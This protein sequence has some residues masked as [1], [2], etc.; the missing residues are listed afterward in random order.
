MVYDISSPF[1]PTAEQL[2]YTGKILEN[3]IAAL[4]AQQSPSPEISYAAVVAEQLRSYT[5]PII[6]F[7]IS[8]FEHECCHRLFGDLNFAKAAANKALNNLDKILLINSHYQLMCDFSVWDICN[9]PSLTELKLLS[10]RHPVQPISG[11][12]KKEVDS[13]KKQIYSQID[14]II[15]YR[16]SNS[17]ITEDTQDQD[18]SRRYCYTPSENYSWLE[19][20]VV[21]NVMNGRHYESSAARDFQI[22]INELIAFQINKDAKFT[23]VYRE[24]V[25]KCFL[26]PSEFKDDEMRTFFRA[27]FQQFVRSSE[28]LIMKDGHRKNIMNG[29]SCSTLENADFAEEHLERR[30][31]QL[32]Y[33]RNGGIDLVDLEKANVLIEP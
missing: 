4:F 7:T 27:K 8:Q 31:F 10:R 14:S 13:F 23:K 6:E 15:N 22:S 16:N 18:S 21:F 28:N 26:M 17:E 11:L 20:N 19:N 3:S 30:K 12:L 5:R 25:K 29:P 32:E 9:P 33:A 1:P 24:G 2:T